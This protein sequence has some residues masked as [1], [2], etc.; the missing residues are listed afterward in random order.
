MKQTIGIR[1][2]IGFLLVLLILISLAIYSVLTGQQA[3]KETVGRSS[4]MMAEEMMKGIDRSIY[5]TIELIQTHSKHLLLQDTVLESNKAFEKVDDINKTIDQRDQK[6]PFMKEIVSNKLSD[7]LREE[8]IAFY[9]KELGYRVIEEVFVTNR[10]GAIVAQTGKISDYRQDDEKWW[11][12]ARDSGF[13]VSRVEYDESTTTHVIPVAVRVD[14]RSGNFIGMD[15]T[16]G[17]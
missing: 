9:E 13:S 4:I 14:D 10:Y 7:S 8:F 1:L 3:L 5:N 2:G 15:H 17:T 11:Q 16:S 12:D 6:T